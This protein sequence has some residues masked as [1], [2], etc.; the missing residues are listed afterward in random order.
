MESCRVWFPDH[1]ALTIGFANGGYYVGG[2]VSMILGS[3]VF[4]L[5][6][7]FT[8]PF[9]VISAINAGVLVFCFLVLP[10][11][12]G[13]VYLKEKSVLLEEVVEEEKEE[14][15]GLTLA[16]LFPSVAHCLM[17]ALCGYTATITVPYLVEQLGISVAHGG[18]YLLVLL[19]I[20]QVGASVSGAVLQARLASAT[21]IMAGGAVLGGVGI[22]LLFPDPGTS[23]YQH[24]EMTAYFAIGLVGFGNQLVTVAALRAIEQVQKELARRTLGKKNTPRVTNLWII[25]MML[26]NYGGSMIALL[27]MELVEFEEGAWI[28]CGCC[29]LS[30][31]ISI[32]LEVA[33][34]SKKTRRRGYAKVE[35]FRAFEAGTDSLNFY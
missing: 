2:A 17:D 10:R 11:T 35:T 19:L 4:E 25:G 14:T 5:E 31:I 21:Q 29:A 34:R 28:M 33:L 27:V 24:I 3:V 23:F 8:L 7:N 9:L 16:V 6:G 13:P 30:L 26:A 1:F 20:C 22:W 12:M 18:C 32:G 15:D